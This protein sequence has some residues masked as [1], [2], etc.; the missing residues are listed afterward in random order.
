[1]GLSGDLLHTPPRKEGRKHQQ[2]HLA[3]ST[4]WFPQVSQAPGACSEPGY[5]QPQLTVSDSSLGRDSERFLHI[6][7]LYGRHNSVDL[8]YT[9][10][11]VIFP[12]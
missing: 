1:M 10:P 12:S 7:L 6:H 2:Q 5:G 4:G 3:Q 9:L 11:N 8:H